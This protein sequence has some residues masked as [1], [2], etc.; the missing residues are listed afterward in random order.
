M[1]IQG[2]GIRPSP[3]DPDY[4]ASA[5]ED[6]WGVLWP[7]C[8]I[9]VLC[10]VVGL[11]TIRP[12]NYF[13]GD[14][15]GL[16]Q[17]LHKLSLDRFLPYFVSDWTEGIYGFQLDELRPFLAFTYW[18]DSRLFGAAN[19]QGYHATNVVLHMLNGLLVLAIARSV[20]PEQKAVGLL[21]ASLFVLMPSHAEP[22]SWISGRVDSL[23]ALFYLGAFLCFV[24]FR[25][26]QRRAWFVA[27]LL[28][29]V[30]G[31][32]AKQSLVT[33]PILILAYD[34]LFGRT[35]NGST[36]SRAISRYASH[37]PFFLVLLTYL[38]LRQHLF[39]N[40]VRGDQL[41]LAAF[42]EFAFRQYFYLTKLLPIANNVSV[43]TR[44][45]LTAITMVVL[46]ACGWSLFVRPSRYWPVI[47]RLIFF[48]AIW[49]AI[50]I[51]PMV[52]TYTSARHLYL[53]S[54]GL[55]I[56]LASL[57]LPGRLCDKTQWKARRLIA[58]GVLVVLYGVALR[59]N[60]GAWIANGVESQKFAT[61]LPPM[62]R[63]LPR[64]SIVLIGIPEWSR[65][66]W[67]W[68]WGLPF[69]LQEPFLSEDLYAQ[70]AIVERPGVYCRPPDQWWAAKQKTLASLLNSPVPHEVTSILPLPQ[71][72]GTLVLTTRKV[73]GPALRLKIESAIGRPVESLSSNLTVAET[74]QLAEILIE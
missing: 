57:I 11:P 20:A 22:I 67:F 16:V 17:H 48:G 71:E 47:R 54:A 30:C 74:E 68:S 24:Q 59:W 27:T 28:T 9:L 53:T 33:F 70:F 50:T 38:E 41:T 14:D 44:A 73:S 7:C 56:A 39:G 64:G 10:L 52:V 19:P 61:A 6:K 69:A 21:A 58:A 49:Y 40:A 63:S 55:S 29:F 46:A 42:K 1:Q 2:T 13:L 3:T 34:V 65:E 8:A 66:G 72:P 25:L 32:F 62:L 4:S 26:R 43:A 18:L 31:L 15:F 51:A 35:L 12:D 37:V 36:R 45:G 5:R 60:I 23:A